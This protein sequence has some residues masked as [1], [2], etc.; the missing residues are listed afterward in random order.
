M[1]L[2]WTKPSG[3]RSEQSEPRTELNRRALLRASLA[4]SLLA[5]CWGTTEGAWAASGLVSKELKDDPRLQACLVDDAAHVVPGASGDHVRRIQAALK[6]LYYA[7]DADE[8]SRGYYGTSTAMAVLQF[9]RDWEIVNKAY[10]AQPDDIVGKMTI[11]ELDDA[12]HYKKHYR[13]EEP[14]VVTQANSYWCWAASLESWLTVKRERTSQEALIKAY[15][16]WEDPNNGGLTTEGWFKVTKD[17]KIEANRYSP[18][19]QLTMGFLHA[20]LK[21]YGLLF[22]VY[23]LAP[24]GPAHTVV[25]YGVRKR[26]SGE[27]VWVMDPYQQGRL[28]EQPLSKYQSSDFVGVFWSPLP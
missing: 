7:I 2:F 26:S 24:G 11:R 19:T 16:A 8:L 21:A 13:L 18:G 12:M 3:H 28:V 22:M 20:Q 6:E 4:C 27:F 9:K 5:A 15:K 1:S 17:Y 23:N 14:P 25:I 10:Q